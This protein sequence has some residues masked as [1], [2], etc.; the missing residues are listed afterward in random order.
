MDW[1]LV[2]CSHLHRLP[3]TFLRPN[4][5]IL[6]RYDCKYRK[7][8]YGAVCGWHF[9]RTICS[10]VIDIQISW[11]SKIN[12]LMDP[13]LNTL[14]TCVNAYSLKCPFIFLESRWFNDMKYHILT[15]QLVNSHAHAILSTWCFF[16]PLYLRDLISSEWWTMMKSGSYS[17]EL[18]QFYN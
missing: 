14:C 10:L 1:S 15:S 11:S 2:G 17:Y 6:W 7:C 4:G 12:V 3:N 5:I 8:I 13:G 16:G 9:S 18:G